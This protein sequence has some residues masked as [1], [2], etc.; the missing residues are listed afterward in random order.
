MCP[1]LLVKVVH[2]MWFHYYIYCLLLV[3]L[4]YLQLFRKRKIMEPE[5]WERLMKIIFFF[6]FAAA[7]I[8]MLLPQEIVD[9]RPIPVLLRDRP[10]DYHMFLISTLFGFVGSFGALFNQHRPKV[11]RFYRI[12]AVASMLSAVAIVIYS[13]V[14]RFFFL[15]RGWV[16]P[17]MYSNRLSNPKRI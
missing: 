6:S 8:P 14:F 9:G 2:V 12:I 5:S 7:I 10:M 15:G 11:E 1:R 16:W 17:L 4:L 13:L 3:S